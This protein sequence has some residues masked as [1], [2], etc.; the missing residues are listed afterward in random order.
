MKARTRF[1]WWSYLHSRK[2]ILNTYRQN[3]TNSNTLK[4]IYVFTI[5]L[6]FSAIYR[7]IANFNDSVDENFDECNVDY[8]FYYV[9]V[10]YLDVIQN[11]AFKKSLNKTAHVN[12]ICIYKFKYKSFGVSRGLLQENDV[13][14]YA[15][16]K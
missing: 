7:F 3:I 9:T 15:C 1:C 6:T 12:C 5:P 10:F 4:A 14:S 11:M 16:A 8:R 2:Y 13:I